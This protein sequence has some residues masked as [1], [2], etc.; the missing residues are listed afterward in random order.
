MSSFPDQKLEA[1]LVHE[2]AQVRRFYL[3]INVLQRMAETAL[4]F[5]PAVWFVSRRVTTDRENCCDDL[6]GGGGC[7]TLTYANLLVRIS[8]LQQ[9][10]KA[11]N[12]R[13]A[14]TSTGGSR[15]ELKQRLLR[16]IDPEA[17]THR[18]RVGARV[19]AC[20]SRLP[21]VPLLTATL[22]R[23]ASAA[24]PK[25]PRRD[26]HR[27]MVQPSHGDWDRDDSRLNQLNV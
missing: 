17:P 11:T 21:A 3:L 22:V 24:S 15:S 27:K 10:R 26:E 20:L 7:D 18:N 4:F 9:I 1:I 6:V 2:L 8:E 23:H 12:L 13:T 16:L 14:L 5:H 25:S 19:V